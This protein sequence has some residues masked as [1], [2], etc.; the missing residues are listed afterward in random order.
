MLEWS[1]VVEEMI[2]NYGDGRKTNNDESNA[3]LVNLE[4]WETKTEIMR[5]K[6]KLR[7]SRSYIDHEVSAKERKMQRQ[8]RELTKDIKE[9]KGHSGGLTII[10]W[11]IIGSKKL[12]E[13]GNKIK[14]Y[15]TG[16]LHHKAVVRFA[17][18]GW[19][20]GR[21]IVGIR[22]G[23]LNFQVAEW[24]YGMVVEEKVAG[25]LKL[26]SVYNNVI[27]LALRDPR[28][29]VK[30]GG[31]RW[32]SDVGQDNKCRR[33]EADWFC[34]QYCLTVLSSRKKGHLEG[35]LT[36]VRKSGALAIYLVITKEGV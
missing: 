31:R 25:K 30:F 35:K 4:N 20:S 16:I 8:L 12:V 1:K 23:S 10:A 33:K 9:A 28:G 2:W 22:K 29:A 19:T 32:L 18:K 6:K 17:R 11:N 21:Q 7:V 15:D 24:R 27:M 14:D 13:I 26:T 5:Q 36:F 34:E 3:V